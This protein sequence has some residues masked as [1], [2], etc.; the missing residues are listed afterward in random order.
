MYK[1]T[2]IPYQITINFLCQVAT[3]F[4]PSLISTVFLSLIV[5]IG[6]PAFSQA[7][8]QK[9]A[10]K[11]VLADFSKYPE[12]WK[13]KG[14]FSK[15]NNIYHIVSNEKV[16]YLSANVESDSVRIFKKIS[17]SSK[18]HPIIEWKWRVKKWPKDKPASAYLYVSLDRDLVG[19]P[20]IIKYVW[21]SDLKKGTIKKGGVFSPTEVVI[22]SG[23]ADSNDWTVQR[24]NAR[25]DFK[26][27]LGRDPKD[28]AYGI[29][30]L[31]DTGMQIDFAK[32]TALRE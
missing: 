13:A 18:T 31:V 10:D 8:N 20:T 22:Q 2:F 12:S 11:I 27:F 21:S 5:I 16:I 7:D 1:I 28:E 29:G 30:I 3:D 26:Q 9:D 32:I 17:W 25:T 19:I 24:L 15:A 23:P 14:G 4:K 6:L